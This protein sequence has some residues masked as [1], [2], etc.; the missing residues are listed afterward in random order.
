MSEQMA[1]FPTPYPGE[2]WY[3]VLSRWYA[4][5]H[6][7]AQTDAL[8][9]LYGCMEVKHGLL[10][11][12]PSCIAVAKKL[13][14]Q[15]LDVENIFLEHTLL[16]YYMR[17]AFQEK[18]QIVLTNYIKGTGVRLTRMDDCSLDGKCGPKY[19]PICY[20]QDIEQYGEPYWRRTHQVPSC[21]FAQNINA[22]WNN[23]KSIGA[24]S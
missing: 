17:F 19:C 12:G 16:S 1:F 18:K 3:S 22:D 10:V 4:R 21:P 15:L 13:P 8:H 2:W 20:R 14:P 7:L 5:S 9:E 24:D 23:L 6:Y 11:P